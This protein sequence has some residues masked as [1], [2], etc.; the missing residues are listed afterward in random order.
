MIKRTFRCTKDVQLV[1][2]GSTNGGVGKGLTVSVGQ[3]PSGAQTRTEF[4]F[5][6]DWTAAVTCSKAVLPLKVTDLCAPPGA[7]VKIWF[8]EITDNFH[9]GDY[10]DTCGVGASNAEKWPGTASTTANRVKYQGSPSVGEIIQPDLAGLLEAIRAAGKKKARIRM[11]AADAS[12]GYDESNPARYC[13]FWSTEKGNH[14]GGFKPRLEV[15]LLDTFPPGRPADV[16]PA[17]TDPGDGEVPTPT[18]VNTTFIVTWRFVDQDIAR[19]GDWLTA[20]HVQ[21]YTGNTSDDANGNI[22]TG[23]EI[24]TIEGTGVIADYPE[25]SRVASHTIVV[26]DGLVGK[27]IYGRAR[28]R[29]RRGLWSSWTRLAAMWLLPNNAPTEPTELRVDTGSQQP[30]YRGRHN[31]PDG[32]PVSAVETQVAHETGD[33]VEILMNT[34]S[35]QPGDPDTGPYATGGDNAD[36]PQTV[37]GGTYWRITHQGTAMRTGWRVKRRHRTVDRWGGVGEFS[38][39]QSWVVGEAAVPNVIPDLGVKQDS[40]TPLLGASYQGPI[41]GLWVEV[42][43]DNDLASLRLWA[44]GERSASGNSK[45]VEY[46]SVGK[47]KPLSWGQP[48]WVRVRIRDNVTKDTSPWTELQLVQINHLPLAPRIRILNAVQGADGVW[49]VPTLTPRLLLPMRDA[50]LPNDSATKLLAQV[51]HAPAGTNPRWSRLFTSA[52]ERFAD[53]PQ[54]A[55]LAWEKVYIAKARH[56]DTSGV[57]GPFGQLRFRAHRPATLSTGTAPATGDP[58]PTIRW[59][60]VFYGGTSQLGYRVVVHDVTGGIRDQVH[61]SGF[62]TDATANSYALPAYI[63]Q[64]AHTYEARVYVTDTLGITALLRSA[65]ATSSAQSFGEAYT[66]ATSVLTTAPSG[67]LPADT[68][69]RSVTDA[70]GTSSSGHTYDLQGDTTQFD[71]VTSVGTL[72]INPTGAP[73]ALFSGVAI[74][75]VTTQVRA[76]TDKLAVGA[77]FFVALYAHA[78]DLSNH[79]QAALR[80]N[81]DLTVDLVIIKTVGGQG[82]VLAT[83]RTAITHAINTFYWI[84]LNFSAGVL[85]AKGWLDGTGEPGYQLTATDL[86]AVLQKPGTVGV[87]A[88]AHSITNAPIT[89][90]FDD[91]STTSP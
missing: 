75:S 27:R 7:A 51:F 83:F 90:T 41:S 4:E 53:V 67:N 61:N 43:S 5:E 9:E 45:T 72:V 82:A 46:G 91:I 56:A 87:G 1:H 52:I 20:S 18:R 12:T 39:W 42:Y 76:K 59:S 32:D 6:C 11:I 62:V 78:V 77:P 69:T 14:G 16:S 22:I 57:F 86:T 15:E 63:L 85:Q 64:N 3:L 25:G 50:D 23:T 47:A 55:A 21:F 54:S 65:I 79:Y 8:E 34:T 28:Q 2:S 80:F 36:E 68:F 74:N 37:P 71:V 70:W 40:L 60:A 73:K 26:P 31:D 33:G 24:Q 29:D 81:E 66:S 88:R 49:R 44:S 89:V 17:T 58:T 38:G 35:H 48:I 84:K 19:G 13:G 30:D 10:A